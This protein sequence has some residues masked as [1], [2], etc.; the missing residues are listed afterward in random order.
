MLQ[1]RHYKFIA[2]ML[3]KA[4]RHTLMPATDFQDFIS[5]VIYELRKDNPNF[6]SKKFL[7]AV[8]GDE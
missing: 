6:N 8:F 3:K 1:R 2:E 4:Q 5:C 7:M